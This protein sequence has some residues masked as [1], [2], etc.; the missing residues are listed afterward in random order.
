M[1]YKEWCSLFWLV[2][3]SE[4]LVHLTDF[5][6]LTVTNGIICFL[7]YSPLLVPLYW[8]YCWHSKKTGLPHSSSTVLN[9]V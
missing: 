7:I 3:E 8:T 1:Q 2:R 6:V 9:D 5:Y 4:E